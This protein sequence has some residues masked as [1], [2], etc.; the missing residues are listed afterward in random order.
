MTRTNLH[1][2]I[3]TIGIHDLYNTH[4]NITIH[5]LFYCTLNIINEIENLTI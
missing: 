1:H 5:A 4:R 3:S 2:Y